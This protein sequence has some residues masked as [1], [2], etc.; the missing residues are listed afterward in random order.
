MPTAKGR[1]VH[2]VAEGAAGRRQG[3]EKGE[4]TVTSA[5]CA[6]LADSSKVFLLYRD[7]SD[8]ALEAVLTQEHEDGQSQLQP[9]RAPSQHRSTIMP[10]ALR[11]CCRSS[12][13]PDG[14]SRTCEVR[15]LILRTVHQSLTLPNSTQFAEENARVS[16]WCDYLQ[17]CDFNAEYARGSKNRVAHALAR[18][19]CRSQTGDRTADV[20]AVHRGSTSCHMQPPYQ[21]K[22]AECL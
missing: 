11:N 1:T 4:G 15:V 6:C 20:A 8:G 13:P 5:A 3:E 16:R 12:G 22:N 9:S 10:S 7:A 17:G 14:C 21:R 19:P 18:I 2:V